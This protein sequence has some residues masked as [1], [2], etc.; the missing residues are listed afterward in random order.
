MSDYKLVT[1]VLNT[2]KQ[3][4]EKKTLSVCKLH[5]ITEE[6]FK[7]VFNEGAIDLTSPVETVLHQLNDELCKALDTIAPL[8]QIQ[9]AV[10]QKQPW[11][12]KIVNARHKVVQHREWIWHKYP[13]PNTWK[14]YKVERNVYN[15]LLVYKKRQLITKQVTDLKGNNKKLYKLMAQLARIRTDNPLP[16]HNNDESLTNHFADYFISKNWQNTRK[17][18]WNSNLHHRS[19]RIFQPFESLLPLPWIKSLT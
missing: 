2:D 17:L 19:S 9:V 13:T 7:S 6:S 8:K 12:N 5:C 1:A 15:R 4:I 3:P 18:H 16:P 10:C 11:F 14:A